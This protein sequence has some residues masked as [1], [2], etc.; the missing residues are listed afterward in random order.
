M[1]IRL[2]EIELPSGK[3]PESRRFY[4][5]A[6][7]LHLNHHEEGLNVFDPGWPGIDLDTSIHVPGKIRLGFVVDNLGEFIASIQGKG[8]PYTGPMPSH[9]G[10]NVIRMEDPDGNLVEVQE[11]TEGTPPPVR[12]AFAN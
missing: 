11:F 12:A 10:M 7:G 1:K 6:L 2:H 9:L 8:I 3:I 5:Q 4:Q